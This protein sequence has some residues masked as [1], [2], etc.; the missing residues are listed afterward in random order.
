MWTGKISAFSETCS[1]K[2]VKSQPPPSLS[3][4]IKFTQ[5]CPV[6]HQFRSILFLAFTFFFFQFLMEYLGLDQHAIMDCFLT[7][8]AL[9]NQ[10]ILAIVKRDPFS[11]FFFHLSQICQF[12]CWCF[13]DV[14]ICVFQKPGHC[15][16][17]QILK[18]SS[19]PYL[20]LNTIIETSVIAMELKVSMN[21]T[22]V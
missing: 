3:Y 21:Q 8:N 14:H 13:E 20:Q 17:Y 18:F 7:A 19:H 10:K 2:G 12:Q 22:D 1:L 9:N 5:F 6:I 16:S 11:L 15:H 4:Q